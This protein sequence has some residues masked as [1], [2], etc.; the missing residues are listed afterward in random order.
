MQLITKPV[1]FSD[2]VIGDEE[3]AQLLRAILNRKIALPAYG[4]TALLLYGVFGTGKTTAAEVLCA[5]IEHAIS[6]DELGAAPLWINCDNQQDITEVIK[7]A[8]AHRAH[9]SFNLSGL[10]YY[11]FDEVDNITK[12]GQQKLKLFLNHSDIVCI[13]TTNYIGEVV[14]GVQSRCYLIDYNAASAELLLP[15]VKQFILQQNLPLPSD[16]ALLEKIEACEGSWREI[17]PSVLM[18]AETQ[19]G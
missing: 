2:L 7:Q 14:E 16:D 18:L 15:R 10:H 1:S 13:L 17:F 6:G 4:K 3:S 5:E 11:V 12:A 19:A 9:V 8:E